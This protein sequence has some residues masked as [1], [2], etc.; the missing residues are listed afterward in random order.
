MDSRQW[1]DWCTS[2]EPV[3]PPPLTLRKWKALKDAPRHSHIKQLKRWLY[4]IYF[5]TAQFD[6]VADRLN[7][8]LEQ[9]ALSPPGS[10]DILVIT[11][12]HT[13]GKSTFIM[14]WARQYYLECIAGCDVGAEGYPV[15]YPNSGIECDLCPLLFIDLGDDTQKKALD[16]QVLAVLRLRSEATAY[17]TTESAMKAI[18]RHRVQIVVIDDVH[19]LKLE[20]KGARQVLDHIKHVN[21]R[22]GKSGASLVLV[23]ANL[24][25]NELLSDPQINGRSHTFDVGPYIIDQDELEGKRAWQRVLRDM[26]NRLL[27]HLPAAREGFLYRDLAGELHSRTQGYFKDLSELVR[28]A[29]VAAIEDGTYTILKRHL[30]AVTVSDRAEAERQVRADR[31]ER[32]AGG[33]T[34]ITPGVIETSKTSVAQRR[35]GVSKRRSTRGSRSD[36]CIVEA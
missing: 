13:I 7:A 5:P 35:K 28:G 8:K 36:L 12:P 20:W 30:D 11:G 33:G 26:E 16:S 10:K 14:R 4:Q 1:H 23:G 21:T 27:P 25:G 19:L 15:W 29:T 2:A 34:T 6:D 22:L 9:N 17:E 31:K 3:E 24:R 18:A 32:L